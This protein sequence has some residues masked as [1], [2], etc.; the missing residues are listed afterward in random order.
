MR[1]I[2]LLYVIT[3]LELGGAQKQLLS[4]ISSLDKERF[5]IF[6]FTSRQGLLMD[7]ALAMSNLKIKSSLFL[8]RPINPFKDLFAL[9]QMRSF[10]KANKIEIVHTH[11]SKAGILGRLA[12]RLS[13]VKII[14]HTVHGWSFHNYQPKLERYLFVLL[15]RFC[16]RFTDKL[17]VVSNFDKQTGLKNRIGSEEKY[18]LIN[19]GINYADFTVNGQDVKKEFGINKD[20]QLIGTVSCFKPQKAVGDFIQ[21]AALVAESLPR[22]K[23]ILVGDGILRSKIAR[24]VK[25]LNL[26]DKFIFAG[27]RNDVNKILSALDIFALSSLWEGLPIAALEALA[28]GLAVVATNTGGI[29]EVIKEGKNGFLVSRR[30]SSGLSEKI[31]MLLRDENLRKAVGN[32]AKNALGHDFTVEQM[33]GNTQNLYENLLKEKALIYAN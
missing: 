11:S 17:I 29:Q 23:F 32:N 28:C 22:A 15:E 3:K 8:H 7:E 27:W 1:K 10:I 12:A 19:Y 21:A 2:N 33:V 18:R 26:Q 16:A 4:L 31:I 20:E 30:D 24:Q 25:K 5:N 9:L 6:L 14:L 13:G